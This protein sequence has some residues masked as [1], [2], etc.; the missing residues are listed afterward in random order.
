MRF[1]HIFW[2]EYWGNITRRGF[3]LFTFGFPLSLVTLPV[4]GGA[5]LALALYSALPATDPRPV[6][7]VD[8]AAVISPTATVPREPVEIIRFETADQA[9]QALAQGD[10]QAYY[11]LPSHYWRTGTVAIRYE[12]PPSQM[13]DRMVSNW[14]EAQLESRVPAEL[15]TRLQEGPEFS[16]LGL[17]D[18]SSAFSKANMVEAF[19]IF[20]VIYFV[21]LVGTFTANFVLESI[22]NEAEDRTLEILITTVSPL[23]FISG[24]LLGLVAVGLTQV[25]TWL[26]AA[27]GLALVVTGW[28]G[29]K[30]LEPVWAWEHLG[31]TLSVLTAA[32][33]LDQIVAAALGLVRVTGGAGNLIFNLVNLV[34]GLSLIYAIYFVPR[35]P[36]TPISV[37]ASLV[38]FTAPVVLLI[39]VVVSEV[40][41]WQVV[42]SQVCLW[43]SCLLGV[44]WLHRLLKA[45]VV[46]STQPFRFVEW[47]GRVRRQA[48]RSS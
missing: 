31:L 42:L 32:Y 2:R 25:G 45:N 5:A 10:I 33:L 39:R 14:I 6:G 36:H 9:D 37:I 19:A 27:L 16:H 22:V 47:L 38:P 43:G 12:V 29:V 8:Q 23:T 7:L 20:L 46:P 26:A 11:H 44:F 48:W 13:V 35:H 34:I 40:P 1:W 28:V 24:K 3:L 17:S 21:R 4:L 30:L 18:Q 41:V 15:L